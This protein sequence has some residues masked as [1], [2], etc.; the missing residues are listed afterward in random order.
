[1]EFIME[2]LIFFEVVIFKDVGD[3]N[4]RVIFH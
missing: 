1:M 2:M 4:K 3:T